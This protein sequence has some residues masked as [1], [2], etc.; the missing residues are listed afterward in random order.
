MDFFF[1]SKYV[2]LLPNSN[3]CAQHKKV[4]QTQTL[5]EWRKDYLLQGLARR[6]GLLMLKRSKL[7]NGLQGRSFYR[8]DL[9]RGP[10][11]V[12]LSS[13]LTAGEV[14]WWSF[15]NRNHQPSRSK[16]GSTWFAQAEFTIL[17][18]G[19][20]LN[21]CRRTQS[22]VSNRYTHPPRRNQV[23][24]PWLHWYFCIPSL[25]SWLR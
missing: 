14:T 19:G 25:P 24:A 4:K 3:L 23:Q 16:V 20:S 17:H 1:F 15:R 7:P 21:S 12:W 8:Q 13:G 10:Q 9:E 18:L 6:K 5:L 22:C 2:V 11:A